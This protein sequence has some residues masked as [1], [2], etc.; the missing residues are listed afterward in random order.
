MSAPE[1]ISSARA[2]RRIGRRSRRQGRA[3]VAL[4]PQL[5]TTGNLA[6]GFYAI[7]SA[8]NGLYGRACVALILA[9]VFDM[10]DGR[11]AR[12]TRATSRFG[13]EYDSIA[14]TV[15]FGLAPAILAFHAGQFAELG[16][17]GWVMAFMY[18]AGAALRLARFNV[19]PGR[20]RGRFEGLPSPAAALMVVSTVLFSLFLEETRLHPRFPAFLPAMGVAGLGL[21]MVSAIPYRNF[22]ETSWRGSQRTVVFMVFLFLLVLARPGLTLFLILLAYVSSGPVEWAWRLRTG[23]QLE[24]IEAP[25]A[26]DAEA[27]DPP[28]GR[29]PAEGGPS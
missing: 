26:D 9:G 4:L 7:V 14:D 13:L 16:W 2:P 8:S 3:Y 18:T 15:S 21:L 12:M 11:V 23:E 19:T 27:D 28:T 20:Y 10:L 6:A 1:P 5:L 17:T 25:G 22:K 29:E 24:E